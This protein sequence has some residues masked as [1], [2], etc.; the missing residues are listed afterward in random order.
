MKCHSYLCRCMLTEASG[1]VFNC[2]YISDQQAVLSLL[3]LTD[4]QSVCWVFC[5][6]WGVLSRLEVNRYILKFN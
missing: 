4:S 5:L 6:F 3:N 2:S 1:G